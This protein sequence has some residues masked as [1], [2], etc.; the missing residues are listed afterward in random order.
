MRNGLTKSV[1]D[2]RK[3]Y[4]MYTEELRSGK[5]KKKKKK[6]KAQRVNRNKFYNVKQINSKLQK[7]SLQDLCKSFD[8]EFVKLME[9]AEKKMD[10]KADEKSREIK[11]LNKAI[12]IIKQ[13]KQKLD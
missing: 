10:F 6:K 11:D 12:A 3:R 1:K 9:E 5:K 13:K 8:E 4:D 7:N 2:A